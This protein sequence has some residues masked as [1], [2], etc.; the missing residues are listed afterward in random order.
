[1][2]SPKV[3]FLFFPYVDFPDPFESPRRSDSLSP[4]NT[5]KLRV[6]TRN[7]HPSYPPCQRS[8]GPRPVPSPGT[9]MHPFLTLILIWSA[10]L[11]KC[12]HSDLFPVL[13]KLLAVVSNQG[14]KLSNLTNVSALQ[15]LHQITVQ[16]AISHQRS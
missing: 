14:K 9:N 13:W 16:R 1:M 15:A 10:F 7:R 12:S 3:S 6:Y 4:A 2:C 5:P 8:V 11:R